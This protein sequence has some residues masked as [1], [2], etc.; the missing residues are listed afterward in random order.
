[1]RA[2]V[3]LLLLAASVLALRADPPRVAISPIIPPGAD[4]GLEQ[5][6]AFAD[7][8]AVRLSGDTRWELVERAALPRIEQEWALK[9]SHIAGRAEALRIG[10]LARADLF[11]ECRVS[12]PAVE[13]PWCRITVVETARAEVLAEREVRLHARPVGPWY[14][15][16][17]ERDLDALATAA[18]ESLAM[19]CARLAEWRGRPV[20]ALLFAPRTDNKDAPNADA[21]LSSL[22]ETLRAAGVR[23]VD[24]VP[25]RAAESEGLLHLLGHTD[26]APSPWEAAADLYLWTDTSPDGAT[27][28]RSWRPGQPV[29]EQPSAEEVLADLRRSRATPSPAER[30]AVAREFLRQARERWREAGL[31]EDRDVFGEHG[32]LPKPSD[33]QLAALGP[34]RTRLAAAAFFAP[35]DG[36]IQELRALLDIT[37]APYPEK[38]LMMQRYC[39]VADHFW[40]RG[41][42]AVD[43]R[44]CAESF[45]REH[46]IPVRFQKPRMAAAAEVLAGLPR[47]TWPPF[48]PLM[49]SW[50]QALL[51]RPEDQDAALFRKIWPMALHAMGNKLRE[52]PRSGRSDLHTRMRMTPEGWGGALPELLAAAGPALYQPPPAIKFTPLNRP[53]ER[54][55]LSVRDREPRVVSRATRRDGPDGNWQRVETLDNGATRT[56]VIDPP[57]ETGRPFPRG[58]SDRSAPPTAPARPAQPPILEAAS[59]RDWTEVRRLLDADDARPPTKPVDSYAARQIAS[60]DQR[61]LR[62]AVVSL[63]IDL[64]NLLLDRGV[65]PHNADAPVF[66][67]LW[68]QAG[69]LDEAGLRLFRRLDQAGARIGDGQTADPF[70]LFLDHQRH[71]LEFD[72]ELAT[73]EKTS[74]A[75]TPARLRDLKARHRDE[76]EAEAIAAFRQLLELRLRDIYGEPAIDRAT[77]DGVTPLVR[78]IRMEWEAGLRALLQAGADPDRGHFQ[79]TPT[80]RLLSLNPKLS[81]IA[82]TVASDARPGPDPRPSADTTVETSADSHDGAALVAALVQKDSIVLRRAAFTPE[83]LRYRDAKNWTVLHHAINERNDAFARAL[84]AAGAPLDVVTTGGQTPL[85]FAAAQRMEALAAAMLDAGADVNLR[86]GDAP[87]PLFQAAFSQN[88]SLVRRLLAAGARLDIVAEDDRRTVLLAAACRADNV[89]V[90]E[91]LSEAGADFHAVSRQGGT[92]LDWAVHADAV[93]NVPYLHSKGVGW[94]K[95]QS[96]EPSPLQ[97][98]AGNGKDRMVRALLECGVWDESALSVAATAETKVLL[99]DAAAR[100]GSKIAEDIALWPVICADRENGVRRAEAHLAAG[101]N[102]NYAKPDGWGYTPLEM[103]LREMN[104]ALVR[105]LLDHGAVARVDRDGHHT[106]KPPTLWALCA[107]FWL[108]HPAH[109]TPG[110]TPP[111]ETTMEAW[112]AYA[113]DMIP[114][115][116]TRWTD[117]NYPE[118]LK[119]FEQLGQPRSAAALRAALSD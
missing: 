57:P 87:T 4:D 89:A 92:A 9:S 61:L 8:L 83:V 25:G 37:L 53:T 58:P 50:L 84:V 46:Y 78:V 32:I 90:L 6:L 94:R 36:E 62:A 38:L 74:G 56:I 113:A 28:L 14:R 119:I 86:A 40:I 35:E 29:R 109:R 111:F 47:E 69:K 81:R 63:Q 79:G 45:T 101:G 117:P 100:R 3:L 105:H 51:I 93:E 68:S 33:S 7:L 13:H 34:I 97:Q 76:K 91:V 54:R 110:S 115:I 18:N 60:T 88:P 85:A 104:P 65:K 114:L 31:A 98:A 96:G 43:W 17:P 21:S 70:I 49:E 103:A 107:P 72:R 26:G 73:R 15:S 12:D 80:R 42:G 41:D 71:R 1:M 67:S 27:A 11:V 102:P 24:L 30:L 23:W 75:D 77:P 108:S 2:F 106:V 16:P 10:A 39:A 59:R 99:E 118:L 82:A 5:G 112:D 66:D 19:A 95:R 64:A 48:G 44:L 20:A 52:S 22:A 116:A 55:G